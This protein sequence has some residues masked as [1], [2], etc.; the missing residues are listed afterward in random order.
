MYQGS[1]HNQTTKRVRDEDNGTLC[2]LSDA[3]V[4]SQLSDQMF[5]MVVYFVL[6][7][8]ICERSDIRIVPVD[9]DPYLLFFQYR[10]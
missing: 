1:F 2:S 9:Q 10:G 6:R 7:C 4:R 3:P 5:G 8:S